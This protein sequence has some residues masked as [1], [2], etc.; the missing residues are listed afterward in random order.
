MYVL[1]VCQ[2]LTGKAGQE[3]ASEGMV[4]LQCQFKA[5]LGVAQVE[6]ESFQKQYEREAGFDKQQ[7]S[8]VT[9]LT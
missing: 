4:E 6:G 1:L 5:Q 9:H 2:Q 7:Q 8:E 3:V